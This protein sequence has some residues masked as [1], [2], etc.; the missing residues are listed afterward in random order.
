MLKTEIEKLTLQYSNDA[1][2]G[3]EL[4]KMVLNNNSADDE[5]KDKY[6]RLSA[7][8]D[9]YRKRVI[10][11]KEDLIIKTKSSVLDSILEIDSDLSLAT[12]NNNDPGIKLII[13]K[14]DKFLTSQGVQT[15]QTDIYDQDLHE[16]ISVVN[17]GQQNKI[18]DVVSKGYMISNKIVK[19]PKIV[20]SN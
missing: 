6:L 10:K 20:L 7:E 5:F 19:H 12:K 8:F 14:L 2:L 11:E 18:V 3:A 16:V 17:T 15:I 4:R 9:N 1:E 13:S